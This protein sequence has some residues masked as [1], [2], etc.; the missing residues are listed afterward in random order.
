M[1]ATIGVANEKMKIAPRKG[2]YTTTRLKSY[3]CVD[4]QNKI[5]ICDT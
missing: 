5:A 2:E 4:V 3:V 1:K